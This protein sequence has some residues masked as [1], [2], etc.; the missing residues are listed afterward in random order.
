MRKGIVG[1]G[2]VLMMLYLTI[3]IVCLN[4]YGP[5]TKVGPTYVGFGT[6]ESAFMDAYAKPILRIQL[7][8]CV[9]DDINVMESGIFV[10]PADKPVYPG[11][12]WP[13]LR[14]HVGVSYRC[15]STDLDTLVSDINALLIQHMGDESGVFTQNVVSDRSLQVWWHEIEDE[16]LWNESLTAVLIDVLSSDTWILN[17]DLLLS[18]TSVG[19]LVFSDTVVEKNPVVLL[20][21]DDALVVLPSITHSTYYGHIYG[22]ISRIANKYN[23]VNKTRLY[24]PICV[25]QRDVDTL[26]GWELDVNQTTYDVFHENTSRIDAVWL[27]KGYSWNYNNAHSVINDFGPT[28]I[29]ISLDEQKLRVYERNVVIL[30]TDVVTGTKDAIVETPKGMFHTMDWNIHY[31]MYGSYGTASCEYFIRL[32]D[33]GIGIH[34]ASWRNAFGSDIY[35]TDGSHGCINVPPDAM[36]EIFKLATSENVKHGIA[37]I[38]Y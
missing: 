13:F 37:V 11:F 24:G 34:D 21:S 3:S 6:H 16:R 1:F 10:E 27:S 7:G 31:Q 33:S 29:T 2:I 28:Y 35:Y 14:Q 26:I 20:L 30:E 17:V 38:I 12:R 19:E 18:G 23:T 32:T 9:V 25:P 15:K 4:H 22:K 36:S 8:E 5:F